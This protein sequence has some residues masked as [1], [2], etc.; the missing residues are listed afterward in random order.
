MF[1]DFLQ[2]IRKNNLIH[3]GDK[4]LLMVSGGIDSTVMCELFYQA[5]LPFGIGHCN[6]NLRGKDSDGDELFV[7]ELAENYNV[8]FYHTSFQTDKVAKNS[9]NSIQMIARQL[10]YDWIKK[11]AKENNYQ[12]IATAHHLDDSI[13]TFFIN[14]L[15]GTGIT[16]LQ[17]V[18]LKQGNII[19]PLLFA[20]KHKI[21]KF[22][23]QNNISWREDKS[24]ESDKYLRN[25]LR[26]HFIPR[27]KRLNKGFERTISKELS[28]FKDAAEIFKKFID[29][30][31]KEVIVEEGKNILLNIKKLKESGYAET[32]LHELLRTYD[33]TPETTELIA[34]RLYST[35]G[36]RFFSP[37]YRLIKDRD[38]LILTKHKNEEEETSFLIKQGMKKLNTPSLDI[39]ADIIPGGI[40]KIKDKSGK[41]LYLDYSKI[42]FPITIRKWQQGDYF[43]PLGM[44]GKKKI[45]DFLIDNKVPLHKKE[46]IWVV[47]SNHTIAGIL[48]YRTDNRYKV[49]SSTQQVYSLLVE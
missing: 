49:T 44:D 33:F 12:L 39:I 9:K 19:R 13:E 17:G 6:F 18:P 45:S 29:E 47:E 42:Q 34:K 5:K 3:K 22:A 35:A 1:K 21:L 10:R 15:R 32:V 8:S 27:F 2:F 20:S 7:K 24:N 48:G 46:D 23:T 43:Y 37:T 41:T 36:K 25:K 38:Y 4:T 31:R 28:Y 16:G 14:V 30:K 11:A 40:S 26:H